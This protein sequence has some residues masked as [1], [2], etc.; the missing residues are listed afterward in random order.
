MQR[1][2]MLEYLSSFDTA[3]RLPMYVIS[4]NRAG[5]APLLEKAKT[6]QHQDLV[7]VVVR[8]SQRDA[9]RRAYPKMYVFGLPDEQIPDCGSARWGAAE[10]AHGLGDDEILMFDD[11]VL[12]LRFLFERTFTK[13]ANVGKVCSGHSTNKD[14]AEMPDLDERILTGMS[15]VARD[16]FDERPRA[17]IGGA[18]KQHMSFSPSNNETKYILNGGITPRQA[19][20]WNL[21]RINEFGISVDLDDFGVTGEDLG[22]IDAVIT[23]G[24]DAFAMPSFAYEHW[25]ESVNLH[26]SMI[27]NPANAAQLHADE[28]DVLQRYPIKD[29]LRTKRSLIDGSYEWGDV[30]WKALAKRRPDHPTVRVTW[31]E[32]LL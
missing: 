21:K 31:A 10:L 16:V 8:K 13:G 20:V 32:D 7:N 6:W 15:M 1:D 30:N 5:S 11:D 9:Y 27:R 12:A 29:Y 2:E 18:I 28:W 14:I 17:V 26:R 22:A 4:Y 24:G 23:A 3:N 25:P 19:M